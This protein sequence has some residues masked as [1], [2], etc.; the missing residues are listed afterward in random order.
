M[1]P[2]ERA[3]VRELPRA[4]LRAGL[5]ALAL[6]SAGCSAS[7]G[8]QKD[9]TYILERSEETMECPRLANSIWGRLQVL[10]SLPDK[11]RNERAAAAPTALEAVGRM[12]GGASKVLPSLKEYDR[13]RAHVRSLHRILLDKGCPPLDIERELAATDAM[14][15]EYR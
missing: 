15:A 3:V 10:K 1:R 6:A 13:E 11:A 7:V 5:C 2:S 9:G 12:F 14:I 8:L 4:T